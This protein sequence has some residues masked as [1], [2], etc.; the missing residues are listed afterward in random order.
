MSA[1]LSF[2]SIWIPIVLSIIAIVISFYALRATTIS[3]L[4]VIWASDASEDED[5]KVETFIFQ[6]QVYSKR[7]GKIGRIRVSDCEIVDDD[8]NT[9]DVFPT[10]YSIKPTE[11]PAAE[12]VR[13]PAANRATAITIRVRPK[14]DFSKASKTLT[15]QVASLEVGGLPNLLGWPT[16]VLEVKLDVEDEKSKEES[17]A[18]ARKVADD[19]TWLGAEQEFRGGY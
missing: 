12:N 18:L 10:T 19:R 4:P 9:A 14:K 15:V 13:K 16:Q 11:F 2:L 3:N 17:Q 6:L 1:V 5:A 7:H 8:G